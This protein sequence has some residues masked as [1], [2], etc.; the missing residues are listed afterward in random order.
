VSFD[1]L[2]NAGEYFSAHYL[3]A[4]FGKDIR[5][6]LLPAWATEE[7]AGRPSPRTRLRALRPDYFAVRAELDAG[8]EQNNPEPLDPAWR[9]YLDELHDRALTAFGFPT[10]QAELVVEHSGGEYRVPV[11]YAAR[12]VVA[13]SCGW[14]TEVDAALDPQ[15]AGR[16]PEPVPVAA[17][18]QLRTG[19]ELATFL[20]GADEPPRYV[21]L[22]VGGVLILA[23][24]HAWGEGRYLGVSLDT[25][26][27][28]NDTGL[29]GELDT[30]AALFSAEALHSPPEGGENPLAHLVDASHRHAVGVSADLRDGLRR[31]V[32]LV[33]N[34]VLAR[35]REAGVRP[36]EIDDPR[37]L[38]RRLRDESLRYLYRILFLLYAEAR[39]DLGILPADYPEYAE[40]YG[41]GRLG[42]LIIDPLVEEGAA[43]GF[44]LYESLD[45]L[46]GLVND[47]HRP[48]RMGEPTGSEDDGIRFE[49]L[50]SDLFAP[51]SITL[52]GTLAHPGWD[53]DNPDEPPREVDT[54]LRNGCLR[55]VL[56]LL[57]LARGRKGERGASS[58]TPSCP[59]TR[60]ARSTKGSCPTPAPSPATSCT[61]SRRAA[62][63]P[64]AAGRS[65]PPPPTPTRTRSSCSTRTRR[66]AS[67]C[68]CATRPDR[69][70]TGWPAGT[71]RPVPPTTRRNH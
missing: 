18:K 12:D 20:F 60:S 32:E 45:L 69:S 11:R 31:S 19:A 42:E 40:G 26:L 23:D 10:A 59:S 48:R 66:P 2:V 61:R 70:S 27:G 28:R 16:L 49:P 7:N 57:M 22:L 17:G 30:I 6:E 13:V 34:E 58:P 38:A 1:S 67:G 52:I 5:R 4:V 47:G 41:L 3:A 24:R 14:A 21:L 35:L 56:R 9:K 25:A 53:P 36:E 44:H 8:A 62:T 15:A 65:R 43:A 64:T 39:P 55:S 46:F 50:H 51:G 29:A 54:R 71:G 63:P 33:A 37:E 68:A